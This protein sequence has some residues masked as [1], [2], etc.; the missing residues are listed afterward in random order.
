MGS[1]GERRDPP[2]DTTHDVES[3]HFRRMR[4]L[5]AAMESL[6]PDRRVILKPPLI[7]DAG[8]A[9]AVSP[10]PRRRYRAPLALVAAAVALALTLW[11]GS[12]PGPP[13]RTEIETPPAAA[14]P[15]VSWVET[16]DERRILDNDAIPGA[17]D[18]F[19]FQANPRILVLDFAALRD[20]GAMLNRVAAFA[21]KAGLPR[22]RLLND[23]ELD[24]AIRGGGDTSETFYYGHDY[25][26][27]SL[28]RFFALAERDRVRLTAQETALR[29]LLL[30][31]RWLERDVAG[32]LISIPGAGAI[33][34]IDRAARATI[35]RHELSHGE[36]FTNPGYAAF[37]RRFWTKAVTGQERAALRRYL[38]GQGY[39]DTQED[40][41]ENEAQAYL[42]FTDNGHFFTPAVIGMR[43][44]RLAELRR[45]FLDQ[46]PPGWLRDSLGRE[47]NEHEV[48][49]RP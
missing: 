42:M 48:G 43:P 26:A 4:A 3:S 34:G 31:E 15:R 30:T 49:W 13:H 25:S 22:E 5:S 23:P 35:L 14:G 28:R 45:W 20:Q 12:A 47:L 40:L 9:P 27:A 32:G 19:R 37:V 1:L 11:A 16:A 6:G 36:Y 21:E 7:R 29:G 18:I 33:G 41:M 38:L 2:P 8:R 10:A 17:I 46:M 24:A 44:E 39:D